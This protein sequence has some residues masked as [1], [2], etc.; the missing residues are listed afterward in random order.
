MG[1]QIPAMADE[2]T[3]KEVRKAIPRPTVSSEALDEWLEEEAKNK[4]LKGP[5]R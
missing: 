2:K 4:G 3:W 5:R 1:S